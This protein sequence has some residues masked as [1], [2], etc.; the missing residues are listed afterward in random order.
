MLI[1]LLI[2]LCYCLRDLKGSESNP[3]NYNRIINKEVV[4]TI[5]SST[6]SWTPYEPEN[7]PLRN[8]NE[9]QLIRRLG[10]PITEYEKHMEEIERII[11][12]VKTEKGAVIDGL[13]VKMDF[14]KL[15]RSTLNIRESFNWFE[16]ADENVK[17]CKPPIMD[18]QICGSCYAFASATTF[19]I[20]RCIALA[21]KNNAQGVVK[22]YSPQDMIS[23]NMFTS[24]CEGGVPDLAFKYIE[25]YGLTT[26]ECQPYIDGDKVGPISSAC[27]PNT[28]EGAGTFTKDYC[29]KGSSV[30]L[31]GRDRIKYEVQTWGPLYASM[32]AYGD[33]SNYQGGIYEH[34]TSDSQGGHAVVIIGWGKNEDNG[35][36]YWTMINSWGPNWG[37]NGTFRIYMDDQ[38]SQPARYVFY[39]IPDI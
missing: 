14:N 34:M 25:D 35:R 32:I 20:R 17:I 5:K 21:R 31:I 6:T 8:Y 15:T 33:L 3:S 16:D 18:Q 1:L 7:N 22:V 38:F 37:E 30:L 10:M 36:E 2:S 4:N 23:C 11:N 13:T 9:D 24:K 19:T 27:R 12:S 39:C 26:N 28:C 29:K